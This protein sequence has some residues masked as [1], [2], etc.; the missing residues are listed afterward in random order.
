MHLEK[1]TV[2]GLFGEAEEKTLELNRDLNIITGRNGS[3]K[4]TLLK[5]SWFIM[6]GNILLA[7]REVEF[8]VCELVTSEYRC[9]VIRTGPQ[10]CTVEYED[11]DEFY[12]FEDTPE[13][14]EFDFLESA[15]DRANP[16]LS[17]IGSSVFFPTF[18]RIEGGFSMDSGRKSRNRNLLNASSEIDDALASL[19]KR[20]G[21]EEHIFVSAISTQDIVQLLLKRYASF[22]EEINS[23]QAEVSKTVI[24]KIRRY[25]EID[26]ENK[27]AN[28][29][30]SETRIDIESIET[31]RKETMKPLDA[32]RVLVE[33][34]FQH[35]GISFGTRLSFGD[36][37]AAVNSN[38]LSAGEKQ[39]LSFIC[40]N[41]FYKNSVIF[42]DE[43]ELS[44]HVDWQRQ[45]FN[46]LNGQ[47][48]G[49]QFIFATHSPF[50][51][52]KYPDKEIAIGFDR[53]E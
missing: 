14:E 41:A 36:A 17:S 5:L 33:K 2:S 50:I 47:E 43:P 4:T 11:E 21:N 37:A 23:F 19:S 9:K 13:V 48:S 51:Y 39:M 46:V 6:S 16:L 31:F 10:H 26:E 52:G 45:L 34:L 15:E 44:L 1:I 25:E 8:K 20:L 40:Y 28:S 30:L 7:L 24:D 53:G 42:I 27:D 32:V 18:R 3:G 35:S 49:N 22:S 38:L 29:I 12:L